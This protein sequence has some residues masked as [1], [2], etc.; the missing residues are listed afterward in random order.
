MKIALIGYG[1][2]GTEIDALAQEQGHKIVSV[3]FKNMSD[4]LDLDGISKC[5]VAIDFTS[6]DIVLSNIRQVLAL[7]KKIV[8]GTTGWYDKLPKVKELVKSN[9]GGLIYAKNFSVGANVFFKLTKEAS[10][11]FY[12]Y[13]G[14]DVY[15]YEI[16]H[17]GKKD[18]PSGTAKKIGDVILQNFPSKKT[19]QVEK[20]DRQIKSDELHLASIRG[21]RNFG[22]HEIIF[23]SN[24]DEVKLSH[25]AH[26]RR[27]FAQGA[28]LAAKYISKKKG[29]YSFEELFEKGAI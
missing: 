10:K 5:D 9:K 13:G 16:H 14:Y 6:A 21:G 25:I 8:I 1:N 17:A 28:L 18:S 20:L 22:T 12:R 24:A 27:G 4:K 26:N 7:K 23:D 2:M 15:G 11:L 19:L 3:S 29:F